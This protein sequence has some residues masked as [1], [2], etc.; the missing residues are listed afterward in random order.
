MTKITF[1]LTL[2]VDATCADM[3]AGSS[4]EAVLKETAAKLAG[5][6][7]QDAVGVTCAS[8]RRLGDLR[9]LAPLAFDFEV[10]V[11]TASAD[12]SQ[13]AL[14]D[15]TLADAQA[16][17]ATAVTNSGSSL[18]FAL[19]ASSLEA[20]KASVAAEAITTTPAPGGGNGGNN[21]GNAPTTAASESASDATTLAPKI[22]LL[23]IAMIFSTAA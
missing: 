17:L 6:V 21:G 2:D 18:T 4:F 23:V 7:A 3:T 16:A 14:A 11:P 20:M 1:S 8:A 12:A 10:T 19:D 9:R 5:D 22:A 15:I 13:T